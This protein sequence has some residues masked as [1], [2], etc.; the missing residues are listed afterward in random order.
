MSVDTSIV[1]LLYEKKHKL[2]TSLLV[3]FSVRLVLLFPYTFE[4][5]AADVKIFVVFFICFTFSTFVTQ[6]LSNKMPKQ[7]ISL[8]LQIASILLVNLF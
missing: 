4:G 1:K 3:P 8:I 7:N 2:T 6:K 5:I